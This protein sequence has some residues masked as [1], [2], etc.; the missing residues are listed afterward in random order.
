[1][2]SAPRQR[3]F[4]LSRLH[5][6]ALHGCASLLWSTGLFWQLAQWDRDSGWGGQS[7]VDLAG[8]VS[9]WLLKMHGAGA[10]GFLIVFGTLLPIHV[11]R[12]WVA[13][14]NRFTGVLF[15]GYCALL[16]LTGYGLYYAGGE[17]LRAI[18]KS[19]H[20]WPGLLSPLMLAGHLWA[21][22]RAVAAQK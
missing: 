4:G 22:R 15:M 3:F 5:K 10:M 21:G 13:G 7:V 9:P 18:M 11:H 20:L 2:T 6:L 17:T 12:A 1:M 16:I 19:A 8:A 14:M